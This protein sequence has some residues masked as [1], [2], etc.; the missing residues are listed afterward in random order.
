V[1]PAE[2]GGDWIS[3]R[4]GD[5][6][7]ARSGA[8][9]RPRRPRWRP[10]PARCKLGERLDEAPSVTLREGVPGG[11]RRAPSRS[12][13]ALALQFFQYGCRGGNVGWNVG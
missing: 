9:P 1:R 6:I 7:A 8:R 2:R 5:W 12:G 3:K 11:E 13:V 10:C 4:G